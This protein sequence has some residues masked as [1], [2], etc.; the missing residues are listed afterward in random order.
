LE[1]GVVTGGDGPALGGDGDELAVGIGEIEEDLAR[2]G[3]AAGADATPDG[4]GLA[5]GGEFGLSFEVMEDGVKGV[6]GGEGIVF[7]E[8]LEE[9]PVA[10]GG[11]ADGKDE[12]RGISVYR[13][14][15]GRWKW[16]KR[17]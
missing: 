1:E 7:G 2:E 8:E 15:C 5:I 11:G 16:G 13:F 6:G 17:G 14:Q 9:E 4:E 10:E 12:D 3:A